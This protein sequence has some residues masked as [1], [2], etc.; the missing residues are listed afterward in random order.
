[1]F[2][3]R[4]S[5][6]EEALR[7]GSALWGVPAD[8]ILHETRPDSDFTP[9]RQEADIT[10]ESSSDWL[11]VTALAVVDLDQVRRLEI[12]KERLADLEGVIL[13]LQIGQDEKRRNVLA[14]GAITFALCVAFVTFS[15]PLFVVAALLPAAGMFHQGARFK[16]LAIQL[17]TNKTER[18][19]LIRQL[20]ERGLLQFDY[21]EE[22]SFT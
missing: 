1:M 8:Q 22:F 16:K 15:A 17:G 13:G 14:W 20:Q 3:R 10:V 18:I 5:K 4:I 2:Y 11:S 7:K 19:Q 21:G 12:S 9:I 6:R